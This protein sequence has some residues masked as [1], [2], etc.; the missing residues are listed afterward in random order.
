MSDSNNQ[1]KDQKG[2]KFALGAILGAVAGVLFA[3]KKGSE[4]RSELK[5]RAEETE[6][7]VKDQTISARRKAEVAGKELRQTSARVT[8]KVKKAIYAGKDAASAEM[9]GTK[10]E[11]E[12]T[13]ESVKDSIKSDES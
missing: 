13:K 11:L 12:S 8:D 4:T 2:S 6:R 3:P 1:P 7:D 10:E 5:S 9:K